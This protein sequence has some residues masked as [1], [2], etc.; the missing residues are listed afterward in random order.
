MTSQSRAI[1]RQSRK[2]VKSE[3]IMAQ[4][5]FNY[6]S[7][8]DSTDLPA[9]ICDRK[10][11]ARP[12]DAIHDI[13]KSLSLAQSLLKGQNTQVL[14]IGNRRVKRAILPD[15]VSGAPGINFQ[16]KNRLFR[17]E[18]LWWCWA[19]EDRLNF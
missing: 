12:F 6:E 4:T 3:K 7:T 17:F 1:R 5:F 16:K 8:C 10:T 18:N 2:I 14:R 9:S 13:L 15:L 11:A 19:R